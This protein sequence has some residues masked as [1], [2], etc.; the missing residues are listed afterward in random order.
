MKSYSGLED[1]NIPARPDDDN[2]RLDALTGLLELIARSLNARER[3]VL[4]DRAA[5]LSL[6]RIGE[7]LGI[8]KERARQIETMGIERLRRHVAAEVP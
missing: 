7:S 3:R 4:F 1:D 8:S 5:G 6:Q 2:D